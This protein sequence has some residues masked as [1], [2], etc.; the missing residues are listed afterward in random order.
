MYAHQTHE[1]D[2]LTTSLPRGG[3]EFSPA[4]QAEAEAVLATGPAGIYTRLLADQETEATLLV[5][6]RV[7]AAFLA[8]QQD[9]PAEPVTAAA[10]A[11]L[12]AE[13]RAELAPQVA[14]L[15]ADPA[16]K[17]VALRGRAPVALLAGCWLDTV[18]QPA[19]QPAIVV[20]RLYAQYFEHK[21]QG[22]PQQSVLQQRRRALEDAGVLLPQVEEADFLT[23]ARARPLA[24]LHGA[25][26][27]AL[28]RLPAAF[29]PE[30]VGVQ[31]AFHALGL[32]DLLNGTEPPLAVEEL[33]T[34]YVEL[35]DRSD[36]GAEDRQRLAGAVRLLVRIEREQLALLTEL[37]DHRAGMSLDA[38]VAEIVER[39]RPY[40]GRQ[41]K[42]VKIGGELLSETF[43]DPQFDL[44]AFMAEFRASRQLRPLR[45]GGCPFTRAVK[46]GGPMFG[47]FD[48]AEAAAFKEWAAAVAAGE[49]AGEPL[50]PDT[51]GD[52]PAAHWQR[53]VL[54]AAPK[55]L[56]FAEAAPADDREFFHRLVNIEQYPN[57]LELAARTAEEGL[58]RAELLFAHGAGGRYT[59]ASWL[60]YSP[61]ALLERVDRIYWDK[62][63]GPFRPLQELPDRDEV[64]FHQKTFALGSLIDGT[65]A[66]RIG[67][68]GRYQRQADAMLFSIYADEMGRGELAKNH[69]TLIRQV[70][71]SMDVQLPHIRSAEFLEQGELPDELYRFSIHQICLAL[72]PDRLHSEIL[73]YNLG[74]EMFGLGEMRLHEVQK[75]RRYNLDTGYEEAHLSIDNFSAGHARQSAEIIISHLD[76]VRREAGQAAVR[77]E[78]RRIWRGY[79]SFAWFVEHHLVNS[80]ATEA[81]TADDLVI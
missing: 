42:N 56:R 29:L 21:G 52:R 47:I 57:T 80:L 45:G 36:T 26:L 75:L 71:A 34:E 72:F 41:H 2:D 19:T 6:R 81:D 33:L 59:D 66:Y 35:T 31:Y 37:V 73:G 76:G 38:R 4:A 30:V 68:L 53:A 11:A 13:A 79:A 51:S 40:A 50:R 7:L 70:L 17:A 24:A 14:R 9:R 78:W 25:F 27:L 58:A 67:N 18:S 77:R 1:L 12:V 55:D 15:T 60:D 74:I 64:I 20:N 62:L 5:A 8:D 49:L 3:F 39:H 54:A 44:A 22:R 43:A 10:L 61:E 32:D 48:E 46:F 16:T 63:V 28:S 23:R 65:W 69:I